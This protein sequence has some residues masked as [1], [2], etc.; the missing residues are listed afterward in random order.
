MKKCCSGF[1]THIQ[2]NFEPR[3][4]N[5]S[6]KELWKLASKRVERWGGRRESNLA[7][8]VNSISYRASDGTENDQK[9]CKTTK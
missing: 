4:L 9:Q 3:H 7:P 6:G 5:A 2:G 1:S 8:N